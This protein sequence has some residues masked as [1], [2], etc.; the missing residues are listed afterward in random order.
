MPIRRT[1]NRG[2][3]FRSGIVI[4][5]IEPRVFLSAASA[6][7]SSSSVQAAAAAVLAPPASPIN[8]V[9]TVASSSQ[10]N[11]SWSTADS[12]ASSYVVERSTAGGAFAVVATVSKKSFNNT[13][14]AANTTYS[15]RVS[16]KSSSGTSA[17]SATVTATTKTKTPAVPTGL[18]ASAVSSS[19][20]NLAWS[21]S[22]SLATA[23]YVDRS[24][25]GNSSWTRLATVT[26]KSYGNTGL[27]ANTTYYYRV[28]ATNSAGTSSSSTKVSAKTPAATPAAP[29]NVAATA[30]SISQINLTWTAGDALATGYL[31]ERSTGGGAF[32]QVGSVTTTSFSNTDLAE[33]TTY[34]YRVIATNASGT[35]P[36][37]LIATASTLQRPA[38]P[39]TLIATPVSISR[40]DLSWNSGDALA[41]GFVVERSSDGEGFQ[42]IADVA[43]PGLTDSGLVEGATYTYRIT[44]YN[45]AGFSPISEPASAATL[46]RPAQPAGLSGSPVSNSQI[47]LA[48][49]SGDVLATGF[50]VER[51]TD[52]VTFTQIADQ[53]ATTFNDTGLS[54]GATYTYRVT[55]YNAAGLSPASDIAVITTLV[56]PATPT[57]LVATPISTTQVDIAWGPGDATAAGY[58]IERATNYGVYVQIADI[59]DTSFSDTTLSENTIY[60][61][62]VSAYGVSGV[63]QASTAV[64]AVTKLG[65]LPAPPAERPSALNTG[66]DPAVTLTTVGAFK[67]KS[68]TTYT[69]L[70]ITAQMT[71]TN[72]MN[73]TFINCVMDINFAQL[74]N[75]RCDGAT[76]IVIDHCEL[77]GASST[78]VYGDGFTVTSSYIHQ[79]KGDGFKAGNNCFIWGNYVAELGYQNL[80]AHADGVQI[81]SKS[82]IRI[83]GNYFKM[84]IDT[85]GNESNSNLFVQG[86]ARDIVYDHNWSLGG[87][88]SIHAYADG[89][90]GPTVYIT[91]NTFYTGTVRYGFGSIGTGVNWE[92]NWTD[93]GFIALP[94]S[95]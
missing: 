89:G 40:I 31:I 7:A 12:L 73:V 45:A 11:L 83:I 32:T 42:Q 61:Y 57:G 1:L 36:A 33:G 87:N 46:Q 63:S 76:N 77:K 49:T 16:A 86:P 81:D 9:A 10:I 62:R 20:I 88:F 94:G 26:T 91:N 41:T 70:Y 23:Y 14:L 80:A 58:R 69:N 29:T 34:S 53:A 92:N 56:P 27:A 64:R 68:D 24:P 85:D 5:E 65:P 39:T 22:D 59:S 75:V 4:E 51:S 28:S 38:M 52:G 78:S 17:P 71:L 55:A 67:P 35:S 90:G 21:T 47:N 8:L 95:L 60:Q 82:H 2:K 48:W 72:L 3:S 18:T 19:Q 84:P 79:S 13:G 74:Y 15:Y 54:A 37:G 30:V 50:I 66:V 25:N 6:A 44:A 43:T 93:T